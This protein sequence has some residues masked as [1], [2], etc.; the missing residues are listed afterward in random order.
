MDKIKDTLIID[1]L[2]SG[3]S[4]KNL[5]VIIELAVDLAGLEVRDDHYRRGISQGYL[6][7]KD[8]TGD[9]FDDEMSTRMN[10]MEAF[11]RGKGIDPDHCTRLESAHAFVVDANADQIRSLEQSDLVESI[12]Y[13]KTHTSRFPTTV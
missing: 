7:I 8:T 6:S 11:L 13:N 1:F 10:R 12:R 3:Q 4:N 9:D 5:T 2:K